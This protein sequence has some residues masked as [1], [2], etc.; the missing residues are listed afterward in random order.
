MRLNEVTYG[1][2][3]PVRGY[4]PG[5]FRFGETVISGNVLVVP[6]NVSAWD[7][8]DLSPILA[9]ADLIDVL[10]Y[11]TGN[12]IAHLPG[13]TRQRL[14]EAGIGVEIMASPAACRTYNVLLGEGRRVAL[15][16]LGVG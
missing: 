10:L 15:A 12:D 5:F 16:A 7:G 1:E 9:A 4:G 14:E 13:D 2:G 8:E 3:S 6:G 11:G